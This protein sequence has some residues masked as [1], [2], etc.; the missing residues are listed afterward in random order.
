METD[1]RAMLRRRVGVLLRRSRE[2]AD[3]AIEDVAAHLE[4]SSAKVR[5]IENG[6][7]AVRPLEIR[8]ILALY[9]VPDARRSAL[10]D[11]AR[12]SR[13]SK[14]EWWQEYADV[15]GPDYEFFVGLEDRATLI[16]DYQSYLIPGLLQ[17]E[18]YM[19]A[20]MDAYRVPADEAA[21]RIR[22]RQKRQSLLVDAGSPAFRAV[23]EENALRKKVGDDSVMREQLRRIV[24]VGSRSRV[25]I[26]IIPAATGLHPAEGRAFIML[27]FPDPEE[28]KVVYLEHLN[29][30]HLLDT[31][32]KTV[33]FDR[34]FADLQAI[35]LSPD[36]SASLIEDMV[37]E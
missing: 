12:R 8:E 14:L 10:L 13:E 28:P 35:A 29:G 19:R 20:V 27:G 16:C 3:L 11:L 1:G 7:V 32:A 30:S 33:A 34:A 9:E 37:K 21:L 6:Q 15:V 22:F 18:S 25:S 17:T 24:D 31:P 36:D 26:Q 23:I 5:R 4:C 2:A